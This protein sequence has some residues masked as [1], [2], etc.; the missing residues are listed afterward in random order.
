MNL[1]SGN[2]APSPLAK[3]SQAEVC[4]GWR[5]NGVPRVT[6]F[7]STYNH[8][9]YID[10]ALRGFL[11]QITDF[12]FEIII[13]DDAS[14]DGTA[15]VVRAYA[16]EYPGI[17]RAFLHK[18]NNHKKSREG[19]A[20]VLGHA[21]GELWAFCDGDDYWT[22]PHKLQSQVDVLDRGPEVQLCFHQVVRIRDGAVA[23]QADW[24]DAYGRCFG[25]EEIEALKYLTPPTSSLVTR[26]LG[27]DRRCYNGGY[28]DRNIALTAASQ[29][30]LCGSNETWAAYRLHASGVASSLG[31]ARRLYMDVRSRYWICRVF[32]VSSAA[33]RYH[34]RRML[35]NARQVLR[36]GW[37]SR[38]NLVTAASCALFFGR[39]VALWA[40]L[41]RRPARDE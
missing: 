21:R 15:D 8:V 32:P 7:C 24:P 39:I 25:L 9:N 28:F 2:P 23:E 10:A 16:A 37:S 11:G 35:R 4:A 40:R 12:A 18:E 6:I 27:F 41:P 20:Y 34:A 19:N 29:G 31:A 5:E 3:R 17:I 22:Y 30:L 38:M 1:M 36:T 26:R 14:T 33:R 13:V